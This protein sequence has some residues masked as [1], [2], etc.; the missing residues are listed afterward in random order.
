MIEQLF[1]DS[2]IDYQGEVLDI[3]HFDMWFKPPQ[4]KPTI[5]LGGLNPKMLRDGRRDQ[6]RRHHHQPLPRLDP[7]GSRDG[8]ARAPS[9]PVAIPTR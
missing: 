1:A 7:A 2:L 3:D 9:G 6:R 5:Y 8:A 4:R